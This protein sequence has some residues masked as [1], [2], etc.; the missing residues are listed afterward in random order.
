[1]YL[2]HAFPALLV[3]EFDVPMTS[4]RFA[5][6]SRLRPLPPLP[7]LPTTSFRQ[8][9]KNKERLKLEQGDDKVK[10]SHIA[11]LIDMERE[12]RRKGEREKQRERERERESES[13]TWMVVY[14]WRV[15]DE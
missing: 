3:C 9:E 1:M 6:S 4:V 7:R 11:R 13:K 2:Y 10:D 8:V 14:R 12:V 15:D 5:L